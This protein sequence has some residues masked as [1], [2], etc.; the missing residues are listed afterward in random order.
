VK[1]LTARNVDNFKL[2][3]IFNIIKLRAK[4]LFGA[5]CIGAMCIG[6]R[7]IGAMCIAARCSELGAS[8]LGASELCASELG[9]C[10]LSPLVCVSLCLICFTF[11][12]CVNQNVLWSSAVFFGVFE[13]LR[14]ATVSFATSVRLSARNTSPPT[15][16]I[17]VKSNF[18]LF[19]RK[20]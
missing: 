14:K 15:E 7:C 11:H 19:F 3:R 9:A 13:K 12:C 1:L 6:A 10:T 18:R 16:R 17:F 8:E 5:R 4:C 20:K 2:K